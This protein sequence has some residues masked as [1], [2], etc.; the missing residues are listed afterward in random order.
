MRSQMLRLIGTVAGLALIA[1]ACTVEVSTSTTADDGS[2]TGTDS[3]P[4]Q[5][6][7]QLASHALVSFD[8]CDSFLDY[9]I[10]RAVDMVGPYGLED[11]FGQL[12]F[13]FRDGRLLEEFAALDSAGD[14]ASTPDSA[15]DGASTPAFSETNVQVLGV[16]EPDIVKN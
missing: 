4:R 3:T 9:V 13:G 1:S 14:G 15:G 5:P 11:P 12:W 7:G 10:A 6:V 16:D 8:A 2:A